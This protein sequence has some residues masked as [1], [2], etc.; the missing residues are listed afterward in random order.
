[1]TTPDAEKDSISTR[2][3]LT[4]R[5]E[6]R[7]AMVRLL[8]QAQ[9]RILIF[10]PQLEPELFESAAVAEAIAHFVPRHRDNVARL[11]VEFSDSFLTVNRR[12]VELCRRLPGKVEVRRIGEEFAGQTD[13]L[14]VV[15]QRGYLHQPDVKV[16]NAMTDTDGVRDAAALASRFEYMWQRAE[17]LSGLHVPGL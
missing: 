12:I 16:I 4:T 8:E 9:R 17:R 14:V 6:I 10:A 15:D 2:Q 1:M 5:A 7:D 11:A 13:L 3:R